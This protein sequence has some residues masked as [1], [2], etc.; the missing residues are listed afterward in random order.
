ME[1]TFEDVLNPSDAPFLYLQVQDMDWGG[2]FVD[3]QDQV[4][5]DR[6]A[7]IIARD[8]KKQSVRF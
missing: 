7:V 6:R 2:A 8:H 3:V 5:K 4:I 1:K